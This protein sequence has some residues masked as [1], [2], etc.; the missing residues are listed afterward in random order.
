MEYNFEVSKI[1]FKQHNDTDVN[2][3]SLKIYASLYS[4]T[5]NHSKDRL[6][7]YLL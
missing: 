2:I 3:F 1:Q 4:S 6:S 5:S 7:Y